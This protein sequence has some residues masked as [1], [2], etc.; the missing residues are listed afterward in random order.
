MATLAEIAAH[1]GVSEATVSRVL[2]D[3]SGVSEAARHAV[4]TA[5][6][7]LGYE[8]PGRLK[9]R[10]S[11]LVGLVVPELENP[12]FPVFA[13]AIEDSLTSRGYTPLLCTQAPGGITED[14]YVATLLEHGVSGIIFVSGRHADSGA[15]HGRYQELIDRGLPVVFVNGYVDGLAAPFVSTDDAAAIEIA[16][17]HLATL[18]H[19]EIGL[20]VG[21][22]RYVPARRKRD[23]F[24]AALRHHL[25][26]SEERAASLVEES[27]FTLEGGAAAT[28]QLLGR[29]ATAIVCASDLMALGAIRA[30]HDAGRT[31]PDEVSV[32]GFDDNPLL[33]FVD[34]PLTTVR[35]QAR[36]IGAAAVNC[37]LDRVEGAD[38]PLHE[39]LFRPE[40][41]LRS[42]TAP[43]PA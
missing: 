9:R 2:N 21:P 39:Y 6:D 14:E 36:G 24:V 10:S 41:V 26:D 28:S 11:G 37:L 20:A 35:Q 13:Q 40:L 22:L 32:I 15:D 42:S 43:P 19:R 25:E 27:L 16:V 31:V 1:A 33:G 5:L 3:K 8:R 7:V 30:V 18:G 23:A 17:H 29:G 12:I 4:I 34:P 38:V